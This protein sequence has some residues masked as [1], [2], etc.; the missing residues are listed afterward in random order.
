MAPL[1]KDQ[2]KIWVEFSTDVRIFSDRDNEVTFK[3]IFFKN[4]TTDFYGSTCPNL[5]RSISIYLTTNIN[6][7]SAVFTPKDLNDMATKLSLAKKVRKPMVQ[8]R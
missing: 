3:W 4:L 6:E 2:Q 5:V 8:K 7:N 1:E